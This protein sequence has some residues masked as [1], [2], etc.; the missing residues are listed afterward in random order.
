MQL[1]SW[2]FS[3]HVPEETENHNHWSLIGDL[4]SCCGRNRTP[5]DD[6]I[7]IVG[8]SELPKR[9]SEECSEC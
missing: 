3:L 1:A 8:L 9:E 6:T 7:R 2:I 5:Q 4:K